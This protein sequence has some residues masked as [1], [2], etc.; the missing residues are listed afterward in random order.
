MPGDGVRGRQ[1]RAQLPLDDPPLEDP[2]LDDP[3]AELPPDP[4]PDPAVAGFD[5]PD[6]PPE[7]PELAAAFFSPPPFS[8]PDFSPADFSDELPAGAVALEAA[9][10]SVR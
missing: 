6:D 1:K 2:P 9:R 4:E 10:E 3:P 8:L 7:S 5:P